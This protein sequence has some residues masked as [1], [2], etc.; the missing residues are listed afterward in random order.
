M[1][2][3]KTN[4]LERRLKEHNSGQV[5]S[6]KARRPFAVLKTI[7]CETELE[8]RELEQKYKKGYKREKIKKEFG[9]TI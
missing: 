6:T 4:N 5:S 1:Y 3:G 7:P 2:V 9:Y 8:A